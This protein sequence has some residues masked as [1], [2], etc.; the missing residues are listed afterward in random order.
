MS[1]EAVKLERTDPATVPNPL[2]EGKFIQCVNIR[3]IVCL[4]AVSSLTLDRTAGCLI[5]G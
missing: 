3:R 4:V 2:G 5:I 1:T